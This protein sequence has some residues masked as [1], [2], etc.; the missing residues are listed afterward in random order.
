M[1]ILSCVVSEINSDDYD[2]NFGDSESGGD[3]GDANRGGRGNFVG[4]CV[5]GFVIGFVVFVVIACVSIFRDDVDL[6]VEALI[7]W[8]GLMLAGMITSSSYTQMIPM[9]ARISYR[10]YCSATRCYRLCCDCNC[11]CDCDD[12]T[13]DNTSG[14]S[15]GN[16]SGNTTANATE[17][18]GGGGGNTDIDNDTGGSDGCKVM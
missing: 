17:N 16:T 12:N 9:C 15:S 4:G 14:N 6:I 7:A 18:T 3:G 8:A 11:N 2:Y 10:G 13:S 1:H 5:C